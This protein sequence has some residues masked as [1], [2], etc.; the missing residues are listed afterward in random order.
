MYNV[1][2]TSKASFQ[3]EVANFATQEEAVKHLLGERIM[4]GRQIAYA[5]MRYYN[6]QGKAID[7]SSVRRAV[8]NLKK[9]GEIVVMKTDK[10]PTT[11]KTVEWYANK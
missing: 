8:S 11:K 1:T 9:K 5:T 7:M 2:A 3:V 6:N 10:C 4:T